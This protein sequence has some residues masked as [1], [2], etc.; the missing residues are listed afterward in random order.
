MA[1]YIVFLLPNTVRTG[2]NPSAYPESVLESTD[3][4]RGALG[5]TLA[6]VNHTFDRSII[7]FGLPKYSSPHIASLTPPPYHLVFSFGGCASLR[8]VSS[9]LLSRWPHDSPLYAN[10]AFMHTYS[11]SVF[12]DLV[13]LTEC[14]FSGLLESKLRLMLVPRDPCARISD[15]NNCKPPCALRPQQYGCAIGVDR[16]H[17]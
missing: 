10:E 9:R 2:A 6:L 7:D 1:H 8:L 17:Q 5:V 13:M 4:N 16:V 15:A 12:D 3:D 14:S 11:T